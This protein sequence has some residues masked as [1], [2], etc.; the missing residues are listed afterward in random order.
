MKFDYIFGNPPFQDS[1]NR[2]KTQHKLWIDF[3][4]K[5]FNDHLSENGDMVWITPSSWGSPSSKILTLFKENNVDI[6]NLNINHHFPGIGSTF[7]YYK[8]NKKTKNK[9]LVTTPENTFSFDV[10]SGVKY[11]PNDFCD[12]SIS[13]HKKVMFDTKEK[14]EVHYDYV[15]CHNVIRHAKTLLQ[16]KI[17][18][19]KAQIPKLEDGSTRKQK[20]IESLKKYEKRLSE[21]V[22]T[23]SEEKT[24]EH[25]Y[26]VFHTNKKV[27][28]SSVKQDFADKQKVMW[29]RSGYTKP[30]FDDGK[31]GCTDMGYYIL[32]HSAQEGE[33][34]EKFLRSKLM[35]YIFKTAKWSGF[36]NEI[37][38]SSIPKID[39]AKDLSDEDYYKIFNISQSEI[40]YIE[41][42]PEKKKKNKTKSNNS[43]TK[44]EQ[45]VK[46]LG[47]VFTPKELVLEMLNH[48]PQQEW[49]NDKKTFID[50]ACGSGNFLVEILDKR[51]SCG[52]HPLDALK[53]VYG[54]DIMQDNV[55]ECKSRVLSYLKERQIKITNEMI[56]LLDKNIICGDGMKCFSEKCLDK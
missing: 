55:D 14:C 35:Q 9:T 24:A 48:V 19:A 21:C 52:V 36:G 34:L 39:L 12:E 18:S 4:L 17:D 43:E 41:R 5:Y 47:E 46:E 54:V 38:F 23:I 20:K 7:S 26:P 2:K 33:R 13:I 25:I 31:L 51:I 16:K 8:I 53:T 28:Y 45:R 37:V 10:D 15:T 22:I 42:E 49:S 30:F 11:F 27:W 44:S 6:L 1:K 50:P 56:A 29:S 32:V 3:T 40:N